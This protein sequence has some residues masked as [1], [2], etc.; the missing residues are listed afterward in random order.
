MERW[1]RWESGKDNGKEEEDRRKV[2]WEQRG[3]RPQPVSPGA[4]HALVTLDHEAFVLVQAAHTADDV[5]VL[6]VHVLLLGDGGLAAVCLARRLS[7]DLVDLGRRLVPGVVV[8]L[9]QAADISPDGGFTPVVLLKRAKKRVCS[10]QQGSSVYLEGAAGWL[11]A[12]LRV[13]SSGPGG[14]APWWAK[15]SLRTNLRRQ[16]EFH[17]PALVNRLPIPSNI[18]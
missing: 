11:S 14:R 9:P 18:N 4:H 15:S 7:H 16:E 17:P 6:L 8:G 13:L 3:P 10:C 2:I 1:E 5:V 12:Q